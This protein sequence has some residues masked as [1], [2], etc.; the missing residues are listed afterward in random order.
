MG[1]AVEFHE[2]IGSTNDRA[3][4]ALREPGGDG[5]AVVADE[6][7]E[8]RGR[9]GRAWLSPPGRNLLV[10][11]ALRPRAPMELA[12][13]IGFSAALAAMRACTTCSGGATLAIRW[14]NDIVDEAGR[15]VA[16]LLVETA[17][18]GERI[19]EAV[20][21]IG[22]NVN[23]RSAEMPDEI[24]ARSTSLADLA[25]ADVDR[26]ALL[27]DLLAALDD[28]LRDLENGISPIP[29]L[30]RH[31][32]LDGRE[33]AVDL[34]DRRVTGR[35]SGIADDGALLLHSGGE[36]LILLVG[37]VVRV[38]DAPAVGALS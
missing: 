15:K 36:L 19:S 4:T 7:T 31:S 12:R 29:R 34:G 11:V 10:S 2:R 14:P 35:A 20:I 37:E 3:R 8:G 26:V 23:W 5:L 16:G 18:E 28:E 13:L 9:R 17:V 38:T 25:G 22:T 30:R 21:G 1:R 27:G 24:A 32:W 6:Q 33:I